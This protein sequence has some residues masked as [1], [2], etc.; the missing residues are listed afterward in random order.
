M[1]RPTFCQ[2]RV[3]LGWHSRVVEEYYT[4]A[5]VGQKSQL[6]FQTSNC[7]TYSVCQQQVLTLPRHNIITWTVRIQLFES[8]TQT[9]TE[10]PIRI[11][12]DRNM[13][14]L[15]K[16]WTDHFRM[17]QYCLQACMLVVHSFQN[18]VDT[19]RFTPGNKFRWNSSAAN[20]L[21]NVFWGQFCWNESIHS[22]KRHVAPSRYIYV[23]LLD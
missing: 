22:K 15:M 3:T 7:L 10:T 20:N 1:G 19:T 16:L 8:G 5:K 6:I 12:L 21:G 14:F 4:I 23:Q 9:E 11:S 18:A 13:R 17:R 2:T